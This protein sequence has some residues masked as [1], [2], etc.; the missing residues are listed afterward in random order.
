MRSSRWLHGPAWERWEGTATSNLVGEVGLQLDQAH[1]SEEEYQG[2]HS[3]LL[4]TQHG[5]CLSPAHL[6]KTQEAD[7]R[8]LS[9]YSGGNLGPQLCGGSSGHCSRPRPS[10]R[11]SQT[12]GMSD[13]PTRSCLSLGATG[14][15]EQSKDL[16][17]AD[18]QN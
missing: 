2:R 4:P 9:F 5:T 13:L 8:T 10:R 16:A 15:G 1:R 3:R 7:T 14:G 12:R 18:V 6:H 17:L 11:Y